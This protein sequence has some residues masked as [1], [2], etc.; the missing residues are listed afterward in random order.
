M[1]LDLLVI[2]AHPDDAEVAVGGTLIKHIKEGRKAGVI[3][4]TCGELGTRGNAE[5]RLN[6]S[7]EAGRVLGLH[8]RSNLNLRDCFFQITEE[9]ILRVVQV[10]RYH[11]PEIVIVNPRTD[12][13]PD[14]GRTSKLVKEAVLKSGLT[15]I[16]TFD[17]KG[18]RQGIW[19]VKN[20]FHYIQDTYIE[21]DILIDISP[22]YLQKEEA[23]RAYRSQFYDPESMEPETPISGL[24]YFSQVRARNVEWGRRI[25]VEFA[26]GLCLDK[27]L[28]VRNLFDVY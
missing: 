13:H 26:E 3:D 25:G 7:E 2:A 10:I 8:H 1:K 20:L 4:L 23:F 14:H 15:G 18:I 22:F 11:Q 27:V 12:R 21:P 19:K 16:Q 6:E 5:I 24:N 17:G 28:G 9:N